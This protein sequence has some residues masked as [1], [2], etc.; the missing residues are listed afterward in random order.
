MHSEFEAKQKKPYVPPSVKKLTLDE[1]R[2]LI[3][4]HVHCTDQEAMTLLEML[5]ERTRFLESDSEKSA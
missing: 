2:Q 5:Q 4:D 1:A 3:L